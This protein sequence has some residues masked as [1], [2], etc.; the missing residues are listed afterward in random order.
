MRTLLTKCAKCKLNLT[1]AVPDPKICYKCTKKHRN[2]KRVQRFLYNLFGS[3]HTVSYIML[4]TFIA[5]NL[6]NGWTAVAIILSIITVIYVALC[7][8]SAIENM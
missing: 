1:D 2:I 5:L 4:A 6:A 3:T 7:V 8:W